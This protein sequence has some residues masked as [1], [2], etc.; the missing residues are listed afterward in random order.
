MADWIWLMV[1]LGI[2]LPLLAGATVW[3]VRRRRRTQGPLR[4]DDPDKP[5]YLTQEDVDA[6]PSP[7][8]PSDVRPR[9]GRAFDFGVAHPDFRTHGELAHWDNATVLVLDGELSAM[10]LLIGTLGKATPDTPLVVV[11]SA[12]APEVAETLAANRRAF[13]LAVL[14]CIA[15]QE[16]LRDVA[17]WCGA[18]PLL[19]SDLAAG[20]VPASALGTARRWTSESRRSWVE[21]AFPHSD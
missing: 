1:A 6:L 15:S 21:P 13:H 17:R 14:V 8:G 16:D 19:G 5:R 2:G 11:A 10:R 18:E 9:H 12:I 4:A 3:D 7:A 20:Y